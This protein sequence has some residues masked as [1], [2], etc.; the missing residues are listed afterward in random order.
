MTVWNRTG[1]SLSRETRSDDYFPTETNN[2]NGGLPRWSVQ[3]KFRRQRRSIERPRSPNTTL[4]TN[5]N[6]FTVND[7]IYSN[8]TAC[9]VTCVMNKIRFPVRIA[10]L[11][12]TDSGFAA[13]RRVLFC[14]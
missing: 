3:G 6:R 9:V 8:P 4:E 11:L 12:R 10:L 13:V 14:Q 2:K 5:T 1:N 7:A